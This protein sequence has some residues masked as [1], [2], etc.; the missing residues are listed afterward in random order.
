MAD[1]LRQFIRESIIPTAAVHAATR[2]REEQEMAANEPTR[3]ASMERE[4]EDPFFNRQNA[5]ESVW[6]AIKLVG[7]HQAQRLYDE[8]K[9]QDPA[10]LKVKGYVSSDQPQD[11]GADAR[12]LIATAIV[13]ATD[14]GIN[15]GKLV[16]SVLGDAIRRAQ[17]S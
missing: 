10:T 7:P 16:T 2:H 5:R 4:V 13:I 15:P 11:V 9:D 14:I 1:L 3:R 8:I 6:D 12:A 17:K